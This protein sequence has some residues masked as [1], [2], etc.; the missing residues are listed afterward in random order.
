MSAVMALCRHW[1]ETL[2]VCSSPLPWLSLLVLGIV[3]LWQ[4]GYVW[5]WALAA[6]SDR[7]ARLAARAYS[8]KRRAKQEARIALGDLAEPSR[9]WNAVERDAWTLV[10]SIADETAPLIFSSSILFSP[11]P[12]HDRGGGA[13]ASI[14]MPRM[15][16]RASAC[17]RP[18]CW[19]SG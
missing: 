4:G 12:E 13:T 19:A 6:G 18:C 15:P 14:R 1:P 9:G 8:V 16:G 11:C 3:W 10:L 17:R 2:L 7:P 5:I